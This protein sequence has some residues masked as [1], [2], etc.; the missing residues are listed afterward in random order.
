[1]KVIICSP[2]VPP[3]TRGNAKSAGRIA[4]ALSALGVEVELVKYADL[5]PAKIARCR[6]AGGLLHGFHFGVSF[7]M[8][9]H[10]RL[11]YVLS[12]TGTD[13]GVDLAQGNNY[14]KF[15]CAATRLIVPHASAKQ[16]V[17]RFFPE[18]SSRVCVIPKSVSLPEQTEALDENLLERLRERIIIFLPAHI[19]PVKGISDA[20]AGFSEFLGQAP[21]ELARRCLLVIGGQVLD[22]DYYDSL[23]LACAR[24][25]LHVELR[26]EQ[27][28][29]MYELADLVLNCSYIEGLS[30]ALLE[31]LHLGCPVLARQIPGNTALNELGTSPRQESSGR[32]SMVQFFSGENGAGSLAAGL[33]RLLR[34][35]SLLKQLSAASRAEFAWLGDQTRE[36]AAY[37]AI[38]E[39]VFF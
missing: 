37:R 25:V 12:Q 1:M 5:T 28:R 16:E 10:V 8:L 7:R 6:D 17:I 36:G 35:E 18:A 13:L 15:V 11:P 39:E 9:E 20:V 27:M 23:N 26:H 24:Q 21:P 34:D 3:S 32:T 30:N 22:R 31:A 33:L 2:A 38:C 14:A 19:R 29:G 4:E